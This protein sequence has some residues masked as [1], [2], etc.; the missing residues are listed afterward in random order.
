MEMQ[1]IKLLFQIQFQIEHEINVQDL[2]LPE[3]SQNWAKVLLLAIK[4]SNTKLDTKYAE[5][6]NLTYTTSKLLTTVSS[7]TEANRSLPQGNTQLKE[8]LLQ[9]EHHQGRNNLVFDGIPEENSE[10]DQICYEKV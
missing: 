4:V 10:T 6:D 3:E 7:L 5:P 1:Q 2:N 8:D 9:V